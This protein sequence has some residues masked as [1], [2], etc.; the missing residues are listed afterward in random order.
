MAKKALSINFPIERAVLSDFSPFEVPITFSNRH[1]YNFLLEHNIKHD[2][3]NFFWREGEEALDKLILI[4]LGLEQ[5][6]QL[7]KYENNGERYVKTNIGFGNLPSICFTFPISHKHNEFRFLSVIHPKGQIIAVDFYDRYKDLI[8]YYSG[9]SPLSLR[10]AK[11]VAG[12]TYIDSKSL[13]ESFDKDDAQIEV[14]GQNYENLRSFFVYKKYRNIFEFYE[15]PDHH[16]CEKHFNFLSKLDVTQCFD[17]IYTHSMAWAIYQ[18]SYAKK[19]LN[20]TKDTFAYRFDQLMQRIN[21]NE[22]NGIIIGPELSRIFA[23]IIMQAI[24]IELVDELKSEKN[25]LFLGK[26]YQIYRYVDDYFIFYNEKAVFNKIRDIIQIKLKSFKLSLNKHKEET[27]SRPIITPITIAKKRIANLI[28]EKLEYKIEVKDCR[29]EDDIKEGNIYINQS[30]LTTEFKSILADSGVTYSDILNYSL[31]IIE[32]KTKKILL[33][34]KVIVK[35]E[36]TSSNLINALVSIINFTYF[37]YSVAP[38]VNS[39][40]KLC[41]IIQQIIL[42]IKD[43]ELGIE[44]QHIVFK[45]I[46]DNTCSILNKNSVNKFTPIETLYLLVLLRQLGKYYWLDEVTLTK[47]FNIVKEN[48]TL[49]FEGELN[50]FSI[51]TLL[52]Y[53]CD[54]KRFQNIKDCLM[55]YIEELY[56][57]RF[58]TLVSDSEMVHLTLDL[59]ACPFIDI[60]FKELILS[61]YGIPAS[62]TKKIINVNEFWFTKWKDFNFA[63]ELDSKLSKEV[64]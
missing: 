4:L 39:T 28:S 2:G 34:Y 55:F 61:K 15:S 40:I 36:S 37:I 30:S 23:E 54:K 19:H 64:Y 17:S 52:F 63:K 44:F 24:D 11:R 8:T 49:K 57:D 18:K 27:Y 14:E 35:K 32:R 45:T 62:Y 9:L 58:D 10:A 12:C 29:N 6:T 42:F 56:L 1:F 16:W 5:T 47:Y 26:D 31:A 33:D 3:T 13:L 60:K 20:S 38:K 21:Y 43:Q 50:Y 51:T 59:I 46:F 53:I 7:T 41:R 48:H 25:S 22:T